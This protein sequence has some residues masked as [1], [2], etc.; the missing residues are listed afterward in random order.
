LTTRSRPTISITNDCRAGLSTALIEPR[1]NTSANTIQASALPVLASAHK[2]SAGTAIRVWV[3]IS[4]R[5]L[6]SRSASRPPH[7]PANNIGTNWSAAVS[8]T[9]TLE[10]VR[11]RT[12]HISATICIQL[13]LSE[14]ICPMK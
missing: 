14:V 6:G 8:P 11:R 2:V 1:T 3:V 9:A 7:T 13:P 4:S 12:S 10:F 5:R